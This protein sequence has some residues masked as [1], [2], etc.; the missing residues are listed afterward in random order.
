MGDMPR[1]HTHTHN[2]GKINSLANPFGAPL[3][4]KS[5]KQ[6]SSHLWLWFD[7]MFYDHHSAHSLLA[8]SH[9]WHYTYIHQMVGKSMNA[10]H[11]CRQMDG[12]SISH[13]LHLHDT[14]TDRQMDGVSI[15]HVLHLHDTQT[16]GWMVFQYLLSFTY[17]GRG[18]KRDVQ[19]NCNIFS[20]K[21]TLN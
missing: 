1:T 5:E 9:L 3:T 20:R 19:T 15:Y 12:V 11:T 14:Q 17:K 21:Q 8:S 10:R 2:E 13:V 6:F 16:D 7:W 18:R 4:I